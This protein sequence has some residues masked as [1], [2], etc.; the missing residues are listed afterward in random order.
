MQRLFWFYTFFLLFFFSLPD[1]RSFY[2]ALWHANNLQL[3]T[4]SFKG[5]KNSN[6]SDI[7]KTEFMFALTNNLTGNKPWT[8]DF[9][10]W[11]RPG[12]CV[13]TAT[14]SFVK[15]KRE[16]C[17]QLRWR[18]TFYVWSFRTDCSAAGGSSDECCTAGR[19]AGD[20]SLASLVVP[21]AT[22]QPLTSRG[23]ERSTSGTTTSFQSGRSRSDVSAKV[24]FFFQTNST[25]AGGRRGTDYL[26][27]IVFLYGP[28]S[29]WTVTQK[30][31]FRN[32]HYRTEPDVTGGRVG[33]LS[34]DSV[35]F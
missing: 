9:T 4:F 3:S 27:S 21:Q 12:R 11:T 1:F 23:G 16:V 13:I 10:R 17:C 31:G 28:D 14:H 29:L 35:S 33:I 15:G 18:W 30:G 5:R 25:N 32:V 19:S 24:F 20:L 7:P 22:F 34:F 2:E 26:L 8:N 6:H